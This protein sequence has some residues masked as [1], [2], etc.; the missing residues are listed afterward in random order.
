[1]KRHRGSDFAFA[2][3][4]DAHEFVEISFAIP[5]RGKTVDDALGIGDEVMALLAAVGGGGVLSLA[6]TLELV[7]AGHAKVLV[8]QREGSWFDGKSAP[9][10][11][12]TDEQ[13]WELAKDVGAFA[14]SE[15]GGLIVIGAGTQKQ[16]GTDVV[17]TVSD[18][19]LGLVDVS[20][21]RKLLIA[22][23]QPRVEG[24]EIATVDHGGGLGTAFIYIPPQRE[25]LKPFVT[26]GVVANGKIRATHVSIPVRDGP[27]TPCCWTRR[28]SR[29]S[30]MVPD[31]LVRAD[32]LGT[33]SY[34]P[35]LLMG[36][37]A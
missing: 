30:P 22:W 35:G 18:I 26:R 27:S 37:A 1:M 17:R 14:N 23:L 32:A 24:M 6:T 20:R 5:T 2:R 4:P 29:P 34:Y 12:T 31:V 33:G 9:Y 25:E 36:Y 13:K 21:Y 10:Q 7:R 15:M 28:G 16:Q 11:L 3:N 19:P 8:G